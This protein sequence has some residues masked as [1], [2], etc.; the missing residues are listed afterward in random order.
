MHPHGLFNHTYDIIVGILSARDHFEQREA[1]RATWLG[2]IKRSPSLQHRVFPLFIIGERACDVP[3]EHRG[4]TAPFRCGM[5]PLAR[6][7]TLGK[8]I[9]AHA[10]R[11]PD[12]SNPDSTP[13]ID[14]THAFTGSI[15]TDFAVQRWISVT[16]LG[17]FDSG[18]DGLRSNITVG[19]WDVVR[20]AVVVQRTVSAVA[21]AEP[22][23][24]GEA[25]KY[26]EIPPTFLPEN[27]VGSIVVSGHGL[28]EP[29]PRR[30]AIGL[31]HNEG[32]GL[33]KL[34]GNVRYGDGDVATFPALNH[35]QS[36]SGAMLFAGT[37]IYSSQRVR[38][39][40]VYTIEWAGQVEYQIPT[41]YTTDHL[42]L[43]LPDPAS[44]VV[45]VG[46]S[47]A[48]SHC[49]LA[50]AVPVGEPAIAAGEAGARTVTFK[51]LAAGEHYYADTA[52][53]GDGVKLK[54]TVKD[55]GVDDLAFAQS[56]AERLRTTKAWRRRAEAEQGQLIAEAMRY[57]DVVLLPGL[58][59][60]YRNL[61][62]KYGPFDMIS[63]HLFRM[64]S[65][66][67]FH[68]FRRARARTP[69]DVLAIVS[70]SIAC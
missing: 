7:P 60:T 5:S 9:A 2:H 27:F 13:I 15:G 35:L 39:A 46:T 12:G 28:L 56:A 33:I 10:I 49:R 6:D 29:L 61:P 3:P 54:V 16:H 30:D 31:V 45:K 51:G 57:D 36:L 67:L 64:I 68:M 50:G 47:S 38:Q 70:M 11:S 1:V 8:P 58:V 48:Y 26:V 34:L 37:F 65:D 23:G 55:Q 22:R 19:L 53:C 25:I 52:R 63:D 69:H 4:T 41:I 43:Q 66:H 62:R 20:G 44:V 32:G 24:S 17:Y 14:G 59:D 40:T 18:G 42:Q 21:T